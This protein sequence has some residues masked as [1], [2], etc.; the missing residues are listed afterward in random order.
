MDFKKQYI[1]NGFKE[2]LTIQ[3][4]PLV[5]S[6]DHYLKYK[7]QYMSETLHNFASH[8]K[9]KKQ[10]QEY[11]ESHINNTNTTIHYRF[12]DDNTLDTLKTELKTIVVEQNKLYN[13]FLAYIKFLNTT[14]VVSKLAP[15]Q[16]RERQSVIPRMKRL[17]RMKSHS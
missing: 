10:L 16:I 14:S 15:V 8:K 1:D 9:L 6:F 3:K 13:N 12:I 2:L 4:N 5:N 17:L 7:Q 11:Q